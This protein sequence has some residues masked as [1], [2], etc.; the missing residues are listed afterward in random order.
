VFIKVAVGH[1]SDSLRL[2]GLP[3]H[4]NNRWPDKHCLKRSTNAI[5]VDEIAAAAQSMGLEKQLLL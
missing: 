2:A 3:A 4:P 1:P 5:T